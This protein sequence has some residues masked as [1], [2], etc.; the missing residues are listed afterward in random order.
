MNSWISTHVTVIHLPDIPGISCGGYSASAHTIYLDDS[1]HGD[2]V[3]YYW[4]EIGHAVDH[5][6]LLF[7]RGPVE[8]GVEQTAQCVAEAVLGRGGPDYS[9]EQIAKGYWNCPDADVIATKNAMI[10]AGIW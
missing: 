5:M 7:P 1:C 3:W 9:A 10:A 6:V 4:H 2:T 8:P